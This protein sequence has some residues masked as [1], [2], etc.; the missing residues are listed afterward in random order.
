VLVSFHAS[1]H[2]QG[3]LELARFLVR[4][5]NALALALAAQSVQPA[6]LGADTNA[7]YRD[8]PAERLMIHQ[9]DTAVPTPNH[10]SWVEMEAAIEDEVEQALYDKKTAAGAVADAQQRLAELV[11]KK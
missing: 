7:A 6:T 9:F 2:K 1:R 10:P 4:P 8:R 3:A 5:D 11:G